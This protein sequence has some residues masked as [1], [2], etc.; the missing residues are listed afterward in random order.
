MRL[1]NYTEQHAQLLTASK[2]FLAATRSE[3]SNNKKNIQIS[4]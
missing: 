2:P 4:P 3:I 1:Q